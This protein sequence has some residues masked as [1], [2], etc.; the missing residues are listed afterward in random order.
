MLGPPRPGPAYCAS[1]GR[2][3]GAAVIMFEIA[4]SRRRLLGCM[5]VAGAAATAICHFF[6]KQ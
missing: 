1:H 5:A 6:W 2:Y 3:I 4:N